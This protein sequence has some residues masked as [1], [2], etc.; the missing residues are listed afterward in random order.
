MDC[1]YCKKECSRAGKSST[2]K[3]KYYC[4]FCKKYQQSSYLYKAYDIKVN[5]QIIEYVKNGCGIRSIGRIIKISN[6]TV[7]KRIRFIASHLE[8]TYEGSV[9]TIYEMDEMQT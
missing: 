8:S 7:M 9:S 3:Q 5:E 1:N 4:V 6:T 2:G